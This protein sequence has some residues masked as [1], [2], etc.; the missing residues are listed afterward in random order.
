MTTKL[1]IAA[2]IA[3]VAAPAFASGNNGH[4]M[5]ADLLNLDAAQFTPNELA[6]IDAEKSAADRVARIRVI[7]ASKGQVSAF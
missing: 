2:L 1:A 5:Q 6:Q 4:Q 3:A 7:E